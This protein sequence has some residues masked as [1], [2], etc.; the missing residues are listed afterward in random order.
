MII[1]TSGVGKQYS[2]KGKDKQVFTD[3]SF[4]FP[5]KGIILL[6]GPSGSGKTTFLRVLGL[7]EKP[8]QGAIFYDGKDVSSFSPKQRQEVYEKK[9]S[10]VFSSANLV[11][12]LT[13]MDN[14]SLFSSD[15]KRIDSLLTRL[16][17]FDKKKT[18][19]EFLSKG[20]EI[21]AALAIALL[22][23][24][25]VIM[26]DEPLANLDA[27][28]KNKMIGLLNQEKNQKLFLIAT[29]E[30]KELVP[31]S[32]GYIS[33]SKEKKSLSYESFAPDEEKHES[34]SPSK[35]P[36]I[37]NN[38]TKTL[39]LSSLFI[40]KTAFRLILFFVL[41]FFISGI[42]LLGY[43][44]ENC[45]TSQI[46]SEILLKA[47]KD[48]AVILFNDDCSNGE[49]MQRGELGKG[50]CLATDCFLK[51]S[52]GERNESVRIFA[53]PY[54]YFGRF[55]VSL[56]VIKDVGLSEGDGIPSSFAGETFVIN[57]MRIW[58][59]ASDGNEFVIMS[60]DRLKSFIGEESLGLDSDVF[61]KGTLLLNSAM[62]PELSSFDYCVSVAIDEELSDLQSINSIK[63]DKDILNKLFIVSSF[64]MV[65]CQLLSL[66]FVFKALISEKQKE[67]KYL[68]LMGVNIS[69]ILITLS[70]F[71]SFLGLF[72][73]FLA[74]SAK[75]LFIKCGN[76]LIS[77]SYGFNAAFLGLQINGWFL[78]EAVIFGLLF[79]F[80]ALFAYK[81]KKESN[82]E[83]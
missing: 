4:T 17:L 83:I 19:A 35:E 9:V 73:A 54:S 1:R 71:I 78:Y 74:Y 40:K 11:R 52:N 72:S 15:G 61:L 13:L 55:E 80:I 41:S 33:F 2:Q 51:V 39:K 57:P 58:K 81:A 14:L 70:S 46:Q 18:K 32:N 59:A 8:S 28:N 38:K 53:D 82:K 27:E 50:M 24:S 3:F 44:C 16:G 23:D 68:C 49:R 31:L 69:P 43:S 45:T 65:L 48:K 37:G 22:K 29:H 66:S 47:D 10:F 75:S 56:G 63:G 34:A 6:K 7:I 5:E 26:L 25:Q 42:S 77:N 76:K 12:G 30:E 67:L 64:L 62:V 60:L 36:A 79:I 21:R 20:E